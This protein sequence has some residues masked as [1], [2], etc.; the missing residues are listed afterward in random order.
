ML[1]ILTDKQKERIARLLEKGYIKVR[2][3]INP[4]IPLLRDG[5]LLVT[6]RKSGA[7]VPIS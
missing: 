4:S 6:V 5:K 7:Y 1:E 3:T 2:N